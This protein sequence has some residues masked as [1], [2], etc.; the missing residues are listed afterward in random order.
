MPLHQTL[1][2]WYDQSKRDFVFR[3]THDSYK[4][5]LSEIRLQQTRT[6]TVVPYFERFTALFPTVE[7]LARADEEDVLRA[8]QGLGYYSRARNLHAAAK[9]VCFELNGRFPQ[10]VEGLL[11]LP[12]IGPYTAAAIAS[13]AFDVPAPAMDGNLTRV[14]SRLHGVRENVEIPSVKR[15]LNEIAQSEMPQKRAGDFNQALMD[16]GA[17]ICTPGTPDCD[18][19]PVRQYCTAYEDGD[20]DMLPVKSVKKAPREEYYAVLLITCKGRI[21]M[22]QRKENLLKNMWVFPMAEDCPPEKLL[23]P[24]TNCA[25]PRY[26][27]DGKHVFTHLIWQMKIYHIEAEKEFR[28]P[29]GQWVTAAQMDALPKPTAIRTALTHAYRI[30]QGG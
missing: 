22:A 9:K 3:G 15:R 30:L 10:T 1:L 5:W 4:V 14:F 2:Q 6:E 28:Y 17:T 29:H 8:W 12:G 27:G 7:A 16:L 25:L 20:A 19:C 24:D 13:I 21:L 11:A 18:R 23:L 26:L